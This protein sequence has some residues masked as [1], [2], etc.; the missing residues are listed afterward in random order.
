[1]D[2]GGAVGADPAAVAG[3]VWTFFG[4]ERR[5]MNSSDFE[6]L[7]FLTVGVLDED[8]WFLDP[9]DEDSGVALV[10][11]AAATAGLATVLVPGRLPLA[12]NA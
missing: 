2:E 7:G 10:L 8:G 3:V 1:L 12:A 9:E 5:L 4:V 11:A 6:V